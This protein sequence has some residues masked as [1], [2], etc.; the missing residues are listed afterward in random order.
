[1][2]WGRFDQKL[3]EEHSDLVK[4]CQEI[5]EIYLTLP[6]HFMFYN[7]VLRESYLLLWFVKNHVYIVTSLSCMLCIHFVRNMSRNLHWQGIA[8]LYIEYIILQ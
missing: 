1:M 5:K 7:T 2:F 6:V 8:M 3:E 4:T